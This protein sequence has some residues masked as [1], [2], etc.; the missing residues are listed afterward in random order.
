MSRNRTKENV[1]KNKNESIEKIDY[2]LTDIA[3]RKDG[4]YPSYAIQ[5]WLRNKNT[6]QYLGV[7]ENLYNPNFNS[8]EFDGIMEEAGANGFMVSAWACIMRCKIY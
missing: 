6:L 2:L 7:W 3:R 4:E 1:T 8:I 5:N